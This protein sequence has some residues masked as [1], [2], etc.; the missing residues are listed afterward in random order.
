MLQAYKALKIFTGKEWLFNHAVLVKDNLI[1]EIVSADNIPVG[2]SIIDY[3]DN[4]LAPCFIDIQIYGANGSLL[5]VDPTVASL[6]KTF[7]YCKAGGA[8]Y[9][10][11]TVATN[12]Y[13]VFY[14]CIDAVRDYWEAGGGGVIGLHI[15]GP[16]I[17]KAKKGAHIEEFIHAP[18]IDQAKSLLEYG[19]SVITMITLAPEICS[20]EVIELIKSY[21][22]IVSAGH[23][24]ATFAQATEAFNNGIT[25]ATHLYNAM[26]PLQHRAPGMVG[27]IMQHSKV[28]CSLVADG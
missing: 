1:Q 6:Q 9:F 28:H 11:P 19:K 15:E 24:N 8:H 25:A 10:Q 12:S 17:N 2:A 14:K 3:G 23:S 22:I 26:S 7:D 18:T 20:H 16:W 13:D 4:L 27:A 21:N 5:S